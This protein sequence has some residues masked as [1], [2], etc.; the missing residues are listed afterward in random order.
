MKTN[1]FLTLMV[2]LAAGS[3]GAAGVA[4]GTQITNVATATFDNPDKTPGQPNKVTSTSNTVTTVVL[5]KPTFD[6]TYSKTGEFAGITDGDTQNALATTK[7][8]KQGAVKPGAKVPTLYTLTNDGNVDLTV[9]INSDQEGGPKAV[10]VKYYAKDADADNDGVL[11]AREIAAAQPIDRLTVAAGAQKDFFQVVTIPDNAAVGE[12][13]GASPEG[14]VVSDTNNG[15]PAGETLFEQQ[16]VKMVNGVTTIEGTPAEN[17]DLQYVKLRVH[18]PVLTHTPPTTPGVPSVPTNPGNPVPGVPSNP[19]PNPGGNGQVVPPPQ[20]PGVPGGP[21]GSLTPPPAVPG[22]IN[23]VVPGVT[24]KP[25]PI[26]VVGTNDQFAYPPA[27]D[28][29]DDDVV[30]FVNDITNGSTDSDTVTIAD[31]VAP[32]GVKATVTAAYIDGVYV[33]D[34]DSN[35]ANGYQVTIPAGK[36]ASYTTTVTYPDNDNSSTERQPIVVTINVTSGLNPNAAPVTAKDTIFPPAMLFSDANGPALGGTNGQPVEVVTPATTPTASKDVKNLTPA[37][38]VAGKA[39]DDVAIFPMD[40]AN[41]GAYHDSYTLS[42]TVMINGKSVDVV[43]YDENG[44][45]LPEQAGNDKEFVTPVVAKGSEIKVFAAIVVPENTPTGDY[46]V[47]QKAVSNYSGITIEDKDDIIRVAS[48]G[49]VVVGKF[50]KTTTLGQPVAGTEYAILENGVTTVKTVA[51][52]NGEL[53]VVNPAGYSGLAGAQESTKYLPGQEYAY[54]IIAKNG[55]NTALANFVLED[56]LHAN[57]NYLGATCS[58]EGKSP[59]AIPANEQAGTVTCTVPNL[60]AGDIVKLN[61]KVSVK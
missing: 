33:P 37:D 50:T 53:H 43:Y 36:T 14:K 17:A 13:F 12:E 61:I 6:I 3:A 56:K 48:A 44:N 34:E 4:A 30:T 60:E 38:V 46:V 9:T 41:T 22:Y 54:E 58:V 45:K 24:T 20:T 59:N 1:K 52:Q 39:G 21:G 26:H 27:D 49:N 42:G 15:V 57:L 47:S 55:Y 7:A 35:P 16:T 5:P 32:G 40:V 2:A 19:I 11:T 25:T 29:N 10:D 23:P 8:E 18:T 31:P 28:N 51:P